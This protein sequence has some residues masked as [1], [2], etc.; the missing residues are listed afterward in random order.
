MG[1][2]GSVSDRKT[3]LVSGFAGLVAGALSMAIGEFISVSS[4]RDS[5]QADLQKEREEQLKSPEAAARELEELTQIY[6]DRGLSEDLARQVALELSKDLDSTVRAHARDELGIDMEDL[7]NPWTAMIS[8]LVAFALGACF[9]LLAAIPFDD[10]LHRTVCIVAS[11]CVG[12]V[13]MGALGSALGGV[14]MFVGAARV[15]VGGLMAMGLT[16]GI[17]TAFGISMD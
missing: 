12:L 15:F 10:Y 1:V 17:G 11:S 9:P 13:I 8:S 6:V 3:V 5:Q 4:A 7:A 16:F 2:A 14:N